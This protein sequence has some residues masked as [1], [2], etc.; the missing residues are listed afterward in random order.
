MSATSTPMTGPRLPGKLDPLEARSVRRVVLALSASAF[1]E[2]C[3]ATA[4]LPL[5][6]IYLRHR[7]SSVTLVG[8]TMAAFF[9]AALLVQYPMGRLSDRIGRRKVQVA[10]LATYALA[11]VLFAFAGAPVLALLLRALQGA[12]AGVVD[13]A[14]AATIGEAVP[15]THQGRAF[16]S[17]YGARTVAMA[18]GPFIGGFA[19]V[20]GMRW[21]FLVAAAG[22]LIAIVPIVSY[23][24][25][26][27]PA[28]AGREA[29][30]PRLQLWRNRSLLGVMTAF[31]TVGLVVGVYEVCWSLLLAW[32]GATAWEIGLSWTL[33]ALPFAVMSFPGGWLVDHF[34]RRY[35]VA[36][37]M[38][39]SAAFASLYP[40][41]DSVPLLIG[42]GSVEAVLVAVG[43]PA[44]AAQ[45]AQSVPPAELGRAQGAAASAQTAATA[46]AAAVAGS[47][48]ALHPWLPFGERRR[49]HLPRRRAPRHLLA[50]SLR[51]RPRRPGGPSHGS[52]DRG[53]AV[54]LRTSAADT[55]R[56][57]VVGAVSSA[58]APVPNASAAATARSASRSSGGGGKY[59]SSSVTWTIST[60]SR[61][62]S[63]AMIC[64]TSQ[65]GAE[66]PAVT[67][68][69]PLKSSGTSSGEL[70]LV[71]LEHEAEATLA[72]ASVFDE[73]DE[74]TTTTASHCGAST[75]IAAWRFVVA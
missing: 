47:M 72:S 49:C 8:L 33:F 16:G 3:G 1:V 22:S 71:T 24:P 63:R 62:A 43:T 11:S 5:L 10:G 70:T 35:L 36:V 15:A 14:N 42:L 2:W 68:T 51:G 27:P 53:Q 59:S 44:E 48:F 12:G 54:G 67:P 74:P 57:P 60:P 28:A 73:F 9:A 55:D 45:L 75:R 19:G 17:F 34:D 37:G 64:C 32:K 52:G 18:I 65:S 41:V 38:A 50:R 58:G 46:V 26:R 39:G 56:S 25:K 4:V 40:F 69:T 6:P 20:A 7:G 23:L 31:V 61:G 29:S 21:V 30:A 66:A 13:V